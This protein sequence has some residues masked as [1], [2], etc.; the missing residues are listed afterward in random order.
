MKLFRLYK[1]IGLASFLLAFSAC[2]VNDVNSA[3]LIPEATAYTDAA[4][5]TAVMNGVYEAAQR[6][7]YSGAVDRGY[8]FGAASTE[9]GDLRGE[10]MYN[11]QLFYE[12]TYTNAWTT[13]TANNN[14]M[15]IGLYRLI[16]RINVVLEGLDGAQ[17]NGVLTQQQADTYRGELYFLRALSNHELLIHFSRP[18]S[19]NP[20]AL[21]NVLRTV[22]INDVSK[23][24]AGLDVPRSTVQESYAA[25][26]TDLNNAET[27]MGTSASVAGP[28]RATKNA[29]IAL[30]TRVKL[31][32]KDWDGV[33]AE[34]DKIKTAYTLTA[35]AETPFVTW[36]STEA[37]FS[38]QNSNVSN[39]GTNA[40][41]ANMYGSPG[42]GG[43]GLVKVSPIIW[44]STFWQT[45][46]TRRT[47][48]TLS[49]STG[50]YS[51]KY[52]KIGV[53]DDAIPLIRFA[54]VVLN[55]SEAYARK[56]DTGNA[57]TLLNRVRDR[58]KV[59]ATPFTSYDLAALGGT[60][61]GVLDGIFKERRIEFLAEGRRWADIHRLAGEGLIPGVPSKATT[62]SVTLLSQ[63][64]TATFTQDHSL[65]YS[66]DLFVWPIPLDEVLLN[67][68]LK[69]QQNKGY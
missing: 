7:W 56:N 37:V 61:A 26:L 35:S 24:A 17:T 15:W 16:N 32:M 23:V 53:N 9:Q 18:Y 28:Y 63:Y 42:L 11:D 45:S 30:K 62:R 44:K 4:K 41:L 60:P 13:T 68:L 33:L 46:D 36:N 22:A 19:D 25:I 27:L 20:S 58:A 67:P 2:E 38:L 55:A 40:A 5:I 51:N 43:R 50:I 65:P 1:I 59:A 57:I 6:G 12:V 10:D 39:P 8:P 14:G 29:A 48:L 31:H 47:L 54:E 34:Y 69:E 64:S 52:R 21:G 49:H 66:S 3:T